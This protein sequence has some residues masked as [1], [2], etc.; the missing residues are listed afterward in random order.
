[1]QDSFARSLQPAPAPP[2]STPSVVQTASV[3]PAAASAAG[4]S[5]S[6]HVAASLSSDTGAAAAAADSKS[7]TQLGNVILA[8]AAGVGPPSC[9]FMPLALG[10]SAEQTYAMSLA[11]ARHAITERNIIF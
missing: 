9:A 7:G 8:Q 3:A 6:V 1:M 5:P 4:I 2:L 10:F 11:R